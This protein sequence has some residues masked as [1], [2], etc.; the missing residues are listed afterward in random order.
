VRPRPCIIPGCPEYAAA[1]VARCSEHEREHV[2][3]RKRQ[4]RT[5]QRGSTRRWRALRAR[6]IREQ[7]GVCGERYCGREAMIVHHID[8]NPENN[9]RRNLVALC[10]TCHQRRH[11][12]R[13]GV[14]EG[15]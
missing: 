7:L 13:Q 8:E 10:V 4:G 1:G 15:E 11:G 2:R 5:G 6:I 14:Q 9:Q 3:E 12:A